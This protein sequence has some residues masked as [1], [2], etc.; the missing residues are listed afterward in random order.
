[1]KLIKDKLVMSDD[2]TL[3]LPKQ[4]QTTFRTK[5]QIG[6]NPYIDPQTGITYLG[7]VLDE[8]ENQTVLG[9]SLY[10]LEKLFNIQASYTV[11]FLNEQMGI[12]TSGPVISEHYAK[13]HCV[14]LFG[15]GMGGAGESSLSTYD[16][17]YQQN[18]LDS[19]L[20]LRFTSDELNE[21]DKDKYFFKK[22][23]ST[24]EGDKTA[25]YLKA[26]ES[27]PRTHTLWK[28]AEGDEDG[29]EVDGD[30]SD[31]DGSLKMETFIE[32]ILKL[33]KKDLKEYFDYNGQVEQARFNTIGLFTGI[34]STVADGTTDYKQVMLF[35][36]YN[37]NNE[38]L[39]FAKDLTILY[40]IYT[41]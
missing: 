33:D 14:C 6:T 32:I 27:T 28:D 39:N 3:V 10:T 11:G 36:A 7:E 23:V 16:V 31:Y 25:Y 30:V 38:M 12:A 20:P 37:I 13:N 29:T 34:P 22:T 18:T 15:L 8:G 9:G 26:F 2:A 41:H 35:S 17:R 4:K 40:R 21:R 19:M 24:D 1:M 5:I